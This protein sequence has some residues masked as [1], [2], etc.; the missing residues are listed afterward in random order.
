MMMM[1]MMIEEIPQSKT[2]SSQKKH[3]VLHL[4]VNTKM[5][6]KGFSKLQVFSDELWIHK[7]HS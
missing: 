5:P 2:T 3:T 1:M 7:Q 6:W 4:K